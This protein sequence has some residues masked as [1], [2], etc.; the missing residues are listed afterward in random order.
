MGE[1][2]G[3]GDNYAADDN[4][5]AHSYN[6]IVAEVT[7]ITVY[8]NV[9]L[10]PGSIM[11][12]AQSGEIKDNYRYLRRV[13][14]AL[15][16]N[17]TGVLFLY[18]VI[19]DI[20]VFLYSTYTHTHIETQT[21]T[22]A[23]SSLVTVVTDSRARARSRR[24]FIAHAEIYR[25]GNNFPSVIL[26]PL[27]LSSS[28][29]SPR[30]CGRD[31]RWIVRPANWCPADFVTRAQKTRLLPAPAVSIFIRRIPR[32]HTRQSKCPLA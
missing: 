2:G 22:R 19:E 3:R 32:V 21:H 28:L 12:T 25:R 20:C 16:V 15:H 10:C 9:Q 27:P 31:A 29:S 11:S 6:F 4:K 1:G 7:V 5:H 14:V 26:P 13:L 30:N 24:E 8:L 18:R 17:W 23:R